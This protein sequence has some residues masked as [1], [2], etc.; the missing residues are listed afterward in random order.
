M[1]YILNKIQVNIFEK[2]LNINQ[3]IEEMEFRNNNVSY[4]NKLMTYLKQNICLY[5]HKD[6]NKSNLVPKY[7]LPCG[8]NFCSIQHLEYFFKNIVKNELTYSNILAMSRY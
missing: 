6:I 7:Q 4:I 2:T 8:C 3:M 1:I 5:C